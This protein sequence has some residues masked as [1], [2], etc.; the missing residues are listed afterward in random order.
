MTK[1]INSIYKFLTYRGV[2]SPKVIVLMDGGICSQMNQYILGQIYAKKG[3]KV[4]Y[5]LTF[6]E[7][8][9]SDLNWQF[10][11]H[12]DLL[13][14]FPYLELKVASKTAVKVYKRKFG[15]VGNN[16]HARVD[17]FSFL[18]RT[19]PIY[20]GGYYHLP[21]K[22]WLEMY[23]ELFKVNIE[24]LDMSNT[25]L[26]Q[27]II[28][29]K[30]TI[31]VHV[32]RGDLKVEVYAY[33]KPASLNYFQSSVSYFLRQL[34]TPYFYFFSDEPLWVAQ[35]LIPFLELS[36][37]YK[38]VDLNGSDKGYMDLFLI[39]ACEH[40]ITSKGT[41]GKYGAL[42]MHNVEKQVVLC[43]DTTEYPW[44]TLLHNPVFL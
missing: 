23:R 35:E 37:N 17:D 3:Y 9:G 1:I 30:D 34:S 25:H 12:F 21:S 43:D 40:Q 39:A 38:V 36:D 31:A 26:Y 7:K 28:A 41:L 16:T 11:R 44:R 33:G 24:V 22:C 32:R 2:I 19:S 15:Y 29:R 6:Y 20:L 42:L 8:W 10:V 27:D 5:D 4:F 18:E 14:A 13:R